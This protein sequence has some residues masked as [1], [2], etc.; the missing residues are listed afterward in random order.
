MKKF[1]KNFFDIFLGLCL[2]TVALV[3]FDLIDNKYSVY[4]TYGLIVLP[5]YWIIEYIVSK[6]NQKW[7]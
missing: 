2:I 7:L 4:A 3:F 1:I 5:V 6:R